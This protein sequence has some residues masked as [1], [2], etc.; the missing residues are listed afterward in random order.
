VGLRV[1]GGAA[2]DKRRV[3]GTTVLRWWTIDRRHTH[4]NKWRAISGTESDLRRQSRTPYIF[5]VDP[6]SVRDSSVITICD[7][8]TIFIEGPEHRNG[9]T[10]PA[11]S[12]PSGRTSAA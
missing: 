9:R 11:W 12:S 8:I 7:G 10:R 2:G 4:L 3:R 1:L 5:A 6:P